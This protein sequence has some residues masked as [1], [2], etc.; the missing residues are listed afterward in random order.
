MNHPSE[1]KSARKWLRAH[2]QKRHVRE[3]AFARFRAKRAKKRAKLEGVIFQDVAISARKRA[4][5]QGAKRATRATP[6]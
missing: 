6:L 3:A 1:T 2:D 5:L 4:K